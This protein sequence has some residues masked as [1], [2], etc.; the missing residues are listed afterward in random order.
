MAIGLPSLKALRA[1]SII[2]ADGSFER[3]AERLGVSRSAVSHLVSDL[4]HQLGVRV[5][6]RSRR[7]VSVTHDGKALLFSM[8]DAIQRIETAIES[9]RRD[10]SQIRLS[11]LATFASCWLL[12]RLPDLQTRHPHLQLS[13]STSIQAVDL[14]TEDFDCAIRHGMGPWPDL[15]CT[16]LFREALVLVGLPQ[17]ISRLRGPDLRS[18]LSHTPIIKARSRPHDLGQWW[19]GVGLGGPSPRFSLVVENREQ[20]LA[21]AVAGAGLTLINPRYVA[22]PSPMSVLAKLPGKIVSLPE[23]F[24]FVAPQRNRGRKNI[25]LLS[26]WLTSEACKLPATD[27]AVRDPQ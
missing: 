20:A 2:A 22:P 4:E 16:F 7:G 15:D 8:G 5:L 1:F 10:R 24:F 25:S 11:T 14:S 19:Q 18:T 13:L 17:L 3:A 23:G 6:Q 27:R 12:P 21:A 26:S 9:F